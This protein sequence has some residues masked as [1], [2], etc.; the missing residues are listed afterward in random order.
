MRIINKTI[1]TF[2]CMIIVFLFIHCSKPTSDCNTIKIQLLLED[3]FK[4]STYYPTYSSYIP[5][6]D[7]VIE[8]TQP[9]DSSK[10]FVYLY[11]SNIKI[12][13]KDFY[14]HWDSAEPSYPDSVKLRKVD[15]PSLRYIHSH[16]VGIGLLEVNDDTTRLKI[17]LSYG[18][19]NNIAINEGTLTYLYDKKNC[20]WLILDST[21]VRY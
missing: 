3:V 12:P 9:P 7:S 21:I 18:K 10:Y 19:P 16:K 15:V 1:N 5:S 14:L 11:S 6:L 20:K 17:H 13:D 2:L 4:K 8:D